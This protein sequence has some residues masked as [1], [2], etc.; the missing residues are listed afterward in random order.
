MIFISKNP[1]FFNFSICT[2]IINIPFFFTSYY[3]D[4][5]HKKSKGGAHS[6]STLS[7][8]EVVF[9]PPFEESF[10]PIGFHPI[11]FSTGVLNEQPC[12]RR[13]RTNFHDGRRTGMEDA[14]RD[15]SVAVRPQKHLISPHQKFF[16]DVII[17]CFIT[18]TI[19][20]E[21]PILE[22]GVY[23]IHIVATSLF[24]RTISAYIYIIPYLH[25]KVKLSKTNFS[26][27]LMPIQKI[28]SN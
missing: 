14:R 1:A 24:Y 15:E 10:Y 23:Y 12:V 9:P 22:N 28:F 19:I 20:E 2:I 26:C 18:T 17:N 21:F 5:M 11:G 25:K 3:L 4:H 13:R 6:H 7:S 16:R 27:S 8:F